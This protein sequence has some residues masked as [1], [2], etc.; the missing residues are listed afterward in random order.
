NYVARLTEG[1]P[2]MDAWRAAFGSSDIERELSNYIRRDMFR[3]ALYTF[4]EK[5]SAVDAPVGPLGQVDGEAFLA[6]FLLQQQRL[7]EAAERLKRAADLDPASPRV[8]T[9]AA[10]LAIARRDH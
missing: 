1:A 7:D 5:L 10:R 2:A 8:A 3:A 6:E 4:P 9:V